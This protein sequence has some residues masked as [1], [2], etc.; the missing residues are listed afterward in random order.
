MWYQTRSLF[1]MY[2]QSIYNIFT[3]AHNWLVSVASRPHHQCDSF[4]GLDEELS[5]H[6]IIFYIFRY[7]FAGDICNLGNIRTKHYIGVKSY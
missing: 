6:K 1:T 5:C 3:L 4:G 2:L 7:I